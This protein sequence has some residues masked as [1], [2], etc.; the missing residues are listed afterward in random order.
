MEKR[1]HKLTFYHPKVE[2]AAECLE[3]EA[4]L[5][6]GFVRDRLLRVKKDYLDVDFVVR[7][8]ADEEISCL[9]KIFGSRGFKIKKTKEVFSFVSGGSRFDFSTMEGER[10]EEDLK[11]RDFTINAIAVNLRELTLPFNDDALLIDPTGGYED[12]IRGVI[13]P[14]SGSSLKDDPLRVLR[15]I[16]LKNL[17]DFEYSEKFLELA[18]L[19]APLLQEIPEERIKEEL[20]KLLKADRFSPALREM[21]QL[22]AFFPVFKELRGIEKIPPGGLHQ[23]DLLE[24]TLRTVEFVEKFAIPESPS[25][26][27]EFSEAVLRDAQALKLTALYHDVGKPLTAKEREGR[28]TFYGHDKVG[29]PIARDALIRLGFG[30]EWGKIAYYVVRNHLRP[31]FLYE[32][33]K[34]KRLSERAIYRFFRDCKGYGFHTLTVSVADYMAT[35]EEME[36]SIGDYLDFIVYLVSFYRERLK[37]LKPLLTG[38]EIMEIKGFERPNRWVGRIKEKMLEL[39]AIGK[40]KTREEAVAFVKGFTVKEEE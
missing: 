30:R 32:L 21:V 27:K 6:G 35:S 16:R 24:H 18:P 2:K 31:F 4:Y 40:I 8:L 36:R 38:E 19:S 26:L 25:Y 29:A 9:E 39:Q 14:V 20:L 11:K 17:L 15:G 7:K 33:F 28:L 22:K 37:D 1:V 10:I 34:E 23:F 3:E 13:R 5:V 12:L